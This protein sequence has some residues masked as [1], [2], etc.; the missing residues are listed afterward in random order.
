MDPF[1]A[2]ARGS[3][4]STSNVTS[5]HQAGRREICKKEGDGQKIGGNFP[6]IHELNFIKC[7]GT[8][9]EVRSEVRTYS[10]RTVYKYGV[11]YEVGAPLPHLRTTN[12]ALHAAPRL[13]WG[14]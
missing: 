6:W 8:K 1:P 3:R 11:Q 9:Y 7:L 5:H 2:T 4:L 13:L 12:D 10:V 14:F